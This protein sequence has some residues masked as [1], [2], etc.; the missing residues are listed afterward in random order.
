MMVGQLQKMNNI[1][2]HLFVSQRSKDSVK[3]IPL[4]T[5]NFFEYI[6]PIFERYWY[7]LIIYVFAYALLY[8][9]FLF[10][11]IRHFKVLPKLIL[12]FRFSYHLWLA[13]RFHAFNSK[14]IF[15]NSLNIFAH[16]KQF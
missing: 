1:C 13:I 6:L 7:F 10:K 11:D 15:S 14:L 5:N 16:E 12:D 2:N 8:S 3:N 4:R 9:R